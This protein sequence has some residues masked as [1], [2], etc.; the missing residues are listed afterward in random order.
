M[1][2]YYY[3]VGILKVI[4]KGDSQIYY[5]LKNEN[6]KLYKLMFIKSLLF[7]FLMIYI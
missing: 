3:S 4:S 6:E 2:F 5:K 1:K 7:K